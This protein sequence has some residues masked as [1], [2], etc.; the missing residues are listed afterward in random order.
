MSL[1]IVIQ[2][3]K[4]TFRR[5]LV[6]DLQFIEADTATEAIRKAE[7]MASTDWNRPHAF[8][9]KDGARCSV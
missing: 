2:E 1:F 4:A 3:P 7:K 8:E 6:V 5:D 9:V